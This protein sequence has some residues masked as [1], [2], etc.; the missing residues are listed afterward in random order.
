MLDKFKDFVLVG[1]FK[2]CKTDD[3]IVEKVISCLKENELSEEYKVS[4]VLKSLN[5]NSIYQVLFG[6]IHRFNNAVQI[7]ILEKQMKVPK[8][9]EVAF[10]EGHFHFDYDYQIV[11][12]YKKVGSLEVSNFE[13]DEN[14]KICKINIQTIKKT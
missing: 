4:T 3:K 14:G 10:I 7:N 8:T 9:N 2:Q 12:G 13:I 1:N 11:I 6:N 5:N